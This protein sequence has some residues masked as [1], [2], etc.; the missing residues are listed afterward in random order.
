MRSNKV[1][2]NH[3]FNIIEKIGFAKM[4]QILIV[5]EVICFVIF[6]EGVSKFKF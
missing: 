6:V 3:C 5:C 2:E 1:L 4:S